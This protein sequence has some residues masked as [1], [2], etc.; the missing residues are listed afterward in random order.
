MAL[1]YGNSRKWI[2]P[3]VL[4]KKKD[5]SLTSAKIKICRN[6]PFFPS[7]AQELIRHQIEYATLLAAHRLAKIRQAISP[8]VIRLPFSGILT[9]DSTCSLD[10]LPSAYSTVLSIHTLFTPAYT[11]T[12]QPLAPWPSRSELKYEG[13][14]RIATDAL[15]RR[16]LPLPRMPGNETVNWQH[17]NVLPQYA[18]EDFYLEIR[19][20]EV[21]ERS[22]VVGEWEFGVGES[23]E[24]E[25]WVGYGD[26][27]GRDVI[28]W[29]LWD[30]I[31]KMGCL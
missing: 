4:D 15:H 12:L 25:D 1:T 16:F 26:A 5:T 7:T 21:F 19:E 2:N 20:E 30:E 10:T 11:S 28:G 29:G 24:W 18:F 23:E 14:D 3:A 8:P 9:E 13:D 22:H 31:E 27:S 17:R 6:S